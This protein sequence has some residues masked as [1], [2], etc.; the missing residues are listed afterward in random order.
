MNYIALAIPAFFLL[1]GVELLIDKIKKT[2]YYRFNDA[3][4]NLNC[5]VGSQVLGVF[6]KAFIYIGYY[7]LYNNYKIFVLPG[8]GQ[9][10][11]TSEVLLTGFVLFLGVDFFYYWFH[12][13]AHEINVLWGSHV[14]HHQ[15]EEYNLTVALRQGWVQSAFSW[16]F[17]LPLAIVGFQPELFIMINAFQTLYQFWIHTKVIDKMPRWFEFVFNTPSHHRVHHGVNPQYID[18]NHGGTLIVYDRMFGTF[19][20][21]VEEVVYG[22]TEQPKSWNPFWLNIEHWVKVFDEAVQVKGVKNKWKVVF[23]LP[24]WKPGIDKVKKTFDPGNFIKYDTK[25]PKGLNYYILFQQVIVLVGTT[26]Y[27]F[28]SEKFGWVENTYFALLI[29]WSLINFG[30]LFELKNRVFGFEA[31]RLIVV[32]FTLVK[33]IDPIEQLLLAILIPA[34]YLFVSLVVLLPYRNFQNNVSNLV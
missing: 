2:K 15:S 27:L 4:T 9:E 17:Y 10:F 24:G 32:A 16:V 13:L 23:G 1:I 28:Y 6:L 14:V 7:F 8:I 12:R 31:L 29:I 25:I 18:K 20:P 33:L 30:A 22:I 11:A 19:E 26:V 21:E 3:V 34:V 5:G